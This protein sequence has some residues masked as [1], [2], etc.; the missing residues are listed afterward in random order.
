[1]KKISLSLLLTVLL[2]VMLFVSCDNKVKE[3]E[4][5]TV[6]FDTA[7]GTAVTS[8]KVEK[9]GKATEPA[10]PTRDG[11]DFSCWMTEDGNIFDFKTVPITKDITLHAVWHE[12]TGEF[13]ITFDSNGGSPVESQKVAKGACVALPDAPTREGYQFRGWTLGEDKY[14][15]FESAV[16]SD[17]TLKAVWSDATSFY[18]VFFNSCGGTAVASQ[19]VASGG[20]VTKPSDPV[21]DG[22]R[23]DGWVKEGEYVSFDF[24]NETVTGD[25]TLYADWS[26]KT[27]KVT[28]DSNGG[29]DVASQIVLPGEKAERPS[30]PVKAGYD[31]VNWLEGDN[32]YFNFDTE[33]IFGDITLKALW[34]EHSGTYTVKFDS[35]GGSEV[36]SQTV[37]KWSKLRVPEEPTKDGFHF[38]YWTKSDG[39]EFKFDSDLI[40]EDTTLKAKW[41][42]AYEYFTVS[43][44]TDGGTAAE[45]QRVKKGEKAKEP[46]TTK[47]GYIKAGWVD[48]ETLR[49]F[50]FNTPITS[51]ISLTV[52]WEYKSY[53]VAFES[54]GGTEVTAERVK[55]GGT[56]Y[57][58]KNPTKEV[59]DYQTF[60][61]WSL[62]GTTEYDFN[63]PVNGNI[64]LK[65]VWRDYKVGD[66]G[67]AGGY[68]FYDCDADNDSGN[69]DGLISSECG[70]RF[71]EAAK[72]DL[73]RTMI[74]GDQS[75]DSWGTRFEIGTGKKNTEILK[76]KGGRIC[77]SYYI[78]GREIDGFSDWYIPSRYELNEMYLVLAKNGLGNFKK[79][80][81]WS[82]SEVSWSAHSASYQN[83]A[84]GE[85]DVHLRTTYDYIRPI[86]SF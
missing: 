64:T 52:K 72:D 54:N 8:Q 56:A 80:K 24:E 15:N 78:L 46:D 9:G 50:S 7:D 67:P 5:Y 71:L 29:S 22:Y 35:D 39:S 32:T 49:E 69:K 70:W 74:F 34:R 83:F 65:A 33:A 79:D 37:A 12:D 57:R 1:M 62:D 31:F 28:F 25:I 21:Y 75:Y 43:F 23:F 3:P 13:V 10:A 26:I 63:S 36:A 4:I 40:Y 59:K 77:A 20:K 58:P 48:D 44:N 30:D 17:L 76:E 16:Y 86:R 82:S 6:T 73:P 42:D 14:Y 61:Y 81:Y 2:S 41:D 66:I 11:Y 27:Y 38:A 19:N 47:E 85:I 68:I 60:G 18:T 45:N 51:D 84:D 53:T 55:A